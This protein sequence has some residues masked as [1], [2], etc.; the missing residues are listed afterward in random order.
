MLSIFNIYFFH[1][2]S[3]IERYKNIGSVFS[4]KN[5]MQLPWVSL[6][7]ETLLPEGSLGVKM[8]FSLITKS[9]SLDCKV[10]SFNYK[11]INT[12]QFFWLESC[13]GAYVCICVC[14][15]MCV[16]YQKSN[17]INIIN[18]IIKD[19][20]INSNVHCHTKNGAYCITVFSALFICCF[21]IFFIT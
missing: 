4:N 12:W 7:E 14:M 8:M 1:L 3:L 9:S 16:K 11:F 10:I 21:F 5:E 18:M 6:T 13:V 2:N 19:F 15:C 17:E 20:C